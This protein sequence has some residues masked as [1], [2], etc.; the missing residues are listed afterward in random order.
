MNDT[1]SKI[2]LTIGIIIPLVSLIIYCIITSSI[3]I[4]AMA[5]KYYAFGE[6][7]VDGTVSLY[8]TMNRGILF[9][10]G[11]FSVLE[12]VSFL[13]FIFKK[14]KLQIALLIL[15]FL[16]FCMT[17]IDMI[18]G[19]YHGTSFIITIPAINNVLYMII[20]HGKGKNTKR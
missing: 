4:A 1:K 15:N 10:L 2:L 12:I 14:G 20:N 17:I 11:I 3:S 5:A 13:A 18:F 9:E 19:I 8:Q 7:T 6:L 16:I